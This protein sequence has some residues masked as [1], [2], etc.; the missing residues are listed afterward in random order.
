[1]YDKTKRNDH[2]W[3]KKTYCTREPKKSTTAKGVN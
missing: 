3:L 1:M 2:D